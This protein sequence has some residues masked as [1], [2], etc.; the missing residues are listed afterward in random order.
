PNNQNEPDKSIDAMLTNIDNMIDNK[1][2]MALLQSFKFYGEAMSS[3]EITKQ[4]NVLDK[5]NIKNY[6]LYNP[7]GIYN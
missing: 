2:S 6:I 3:D 5:H 1:S 7:N 4:I